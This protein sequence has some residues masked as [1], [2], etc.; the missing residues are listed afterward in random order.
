MVT[1]L[2]TNSPNP[3]IWKSD[4]QLVLHFYIK[5][6]LSSIVQEPL[7]CPEMEELFSYLGSLMGSWLGISVW[8]SVGIS[9]NAYWKVVQMKRKLRKK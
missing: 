6:G 7:T 4:L 3:S 2:E 5:L 1:K 8:A 9:E